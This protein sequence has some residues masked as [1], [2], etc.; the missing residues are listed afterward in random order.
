VTSI[1]LKFYAFNVDGLTH[2]RISLINKL[3]LTNLIK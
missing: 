1:E 3:K 2:K